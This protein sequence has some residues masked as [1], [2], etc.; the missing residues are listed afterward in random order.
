MIDEQVDKLFQKLERQLL[1]QMPSVQIALLDRAAS[2]EPCRVGCRGFE[3]L[4]RHAVAALNEAASISDE[5][6]RRN[7]SRALIARL[8]QGTMDRTASMSLTPKIIERTR[9]WLPR[10]AEFLEAL[11]TSDYC[12]PQDLFCKDY[13]FVTMM[14]V[15]CGAQVLD[16]NDG[17][18][19]K[20]SLKLALQYPLAGVRAA[21]SAWFRPH[22]ESRYL[23]EF[24]DLGWKD[25]Y[26]EVAE[27]L[28]LHPSVAG[29]VATS[30]FYDP[31]LSEVSPR[32]SYL[33]QLPADNGAML[34]RHGTTDFDIHSAIATSPTRRALYD[35]G[36][37]KPVCYS[38]L[39]DRRDLIAWAS[40]P[41]ANA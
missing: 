41:S 7:F 12:F 27:L 35:A 6:E 25:C 9:Q 10:L 30:W 1:S 4:G 32:L 38:I 14:T 34:V 26:R 16:L 21:K 20:T 19:P 31:A 29:M 22:T 33:R 40:N 2:I 23:D 28:E 8:A 37:Y 11:V 39:W 5:C 18:G 13:R 36:K 3:N 24:S 17:V 15:P